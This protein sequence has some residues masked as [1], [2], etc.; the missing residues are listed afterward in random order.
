MAKSK[1]ITLVTPKFRV[2]FPKIF[3]PEFNKLSKKDEYSV[4]ALFEKGQDISK[5]VDAAMKVAK[6]SWGEN[7]KKWPKKWKNPI[8]DQAEREKEDDDTGAKSMP[9]GYV[10][11]AK[12]IQFKSK[13]KPGIIG[14]KKEPIEDEEEFYAGCYARASVFVNTFNFEDGMNTG[15]TFSLNHLQKVADGE[16]LSGRR[17]AEDCFEAIESDEDETVDELADDDENPFA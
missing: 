11:G 3:T 17:K 8:K 12:M 16:P 14:K 1:G 7:P 4:V 10:K 9:E 6:E 13:N 2:S 5:L 15:V